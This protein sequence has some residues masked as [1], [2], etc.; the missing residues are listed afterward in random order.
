MAYRTKNIF[1]T[2]DELLTKAK[3]YEQTMTK[4][5]SEKTQKVSRVPST[6][7]R[8]VYRFRALYLWQC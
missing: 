5:E 1:L 4:L 7:S 2:Q 6:H 8:H 3:Q